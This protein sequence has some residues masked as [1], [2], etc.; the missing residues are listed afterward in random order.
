M[1]YFSEARKFL[2]NEHPLQA[3]MIEARLFT[4]T[5]QLVG[6]FN[7]VKDARQFHIDL[8]NG[9]YLDLITE[10][11]VKVSQ[12]IIHTQGPIIL[13]IPSSTLV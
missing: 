1:P 5:V 10:M 4:P 9:D 11:K 12:G 6:L 2:V 7:L 8:P 3:H 13:V